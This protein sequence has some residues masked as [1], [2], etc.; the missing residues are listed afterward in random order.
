M[1]LSDAAL[2]E[3]RE[4]AIE[5]NLSILRKR[6]TELGVAEAVIQRQGAERIVVELLGVQDTARAKKKFGATATLEFR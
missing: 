2:N 5:Q 1:A 3:A 6:V 4:S